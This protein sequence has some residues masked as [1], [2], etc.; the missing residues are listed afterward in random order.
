MLGSLERAAYVGVQHTKRSA[1][2]RKM[3]FIEREWYMMMEG[4]GK[5]SVEVVWLIVLG[6]DGE[7]V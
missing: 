1:N 2:I 3:I 4:E 7:V 6:L 5:L